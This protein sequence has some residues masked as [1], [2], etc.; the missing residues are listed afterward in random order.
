MMTGVGSVGCI[1]LLRFQSAN[2]SNECFQQANFWA[3][4]YN[5]QLQSMLQGLKAELKDINYS[6]IDTYSL[7][8]AVIQSPAT[9]GKFPT[10]ITLFSYLSQETNSKF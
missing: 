9:Y 10:S 3:N 4:K 1:P 2:K 8:L 6:F 5:Q 7:L